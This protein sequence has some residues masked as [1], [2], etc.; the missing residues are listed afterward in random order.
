M[1]T[2]KGHGPDPGITLW[3]DSAGRFPRLSAEYTNQIANEIQSLPEDSAK[4]RRL[5]KKL[6]NH[7][8]LLAANFVKRFMDG[9]SHNKWGSNETLDYLQVGAIG[10]MRAAEKFDPRR[11]YTFAT[12]ATHWMHSTV[13]RYNLKTMTP[14]HVTESAARKY[15]YYKKN[16]KMSA[17]GAPREAKEDEVR[18]LEHLLGNAYNCLSLDASF[19]EDGSP[20]VESVATTSRQSVGWKHIYSSLRQV[21]IKPI[22][23]QILKDYYVNDRTIAEIADRMAL[24]VQ[25]VRQYKKRAMATTGRRASDIPW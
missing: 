21:G 16:G 18:L 1:R 10:L 23:I 4:R 19:T 13:G 20:L 3:L 25:Q 7:N 11:G 15:L 14:V 17:A 24:S 2:N 9:K 8:L 12:Y 6:V 22:E 5:V